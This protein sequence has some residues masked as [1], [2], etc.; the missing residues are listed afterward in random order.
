M[1]RKYL[2]RELLQYLRRLWPFMI[3][4][5][6]AGLLAFACLANDHNDI[7]MW[8][9]IFACTIFALAGL[10]YVI[11]GLIHTYMS[12]SKS[13]RLE[14][15]ERPQYLPKLIRAQALAFV[16]FVV[17]SV[18]L[19]IASVSIFAWQSVQHTFAAIDTDWKYFLEFIFYLLIISV[20]A[21]IIPITWIVVSRFAKNKR[22]INRLSVTIGV[23]ALLML[24]ATVVIE[25]LL[26]IHAPSTDMATTW[27]T[28]IIFLILYLFIDIGMF[29]ITF[30]V[31]KK[32]S[33]NNQKSD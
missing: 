33:V 8:G 32:T 25:I 14:Q 6:V 7:E 4:V 15:I 20:A 24:P 31:L 1:F 5:I 23:I 26:L 16:V 17:F 22:N 29:L 11:R 3:G 2:G 27:L 10:A 12:A 19:F 9:M 18:L 21:Y 13:I 28:T 30:Q